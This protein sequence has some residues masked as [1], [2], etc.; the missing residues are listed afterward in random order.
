MSEHINVTFD[1]GIATLLL[2]LPG[3]NKIG[4][5]FGAALTSGLDQALAHEGLKGIVLGSGH[6]DFCVGADID[7]L[8]AERDPAKIVDACTQLNAL[9]RRIETC[10]VPVVAAL[11]GSALG[12]GYELALACH[13][14]IALDSGRI[15][16]G[17]P[18][19]SLGVIPGAGGT[20]R[21]PYIMGLQGAMEHMAAGTPLRAPKAL[22]KGMLN[23][24]ASDADDL[25]Q[26]ARAW[27]LENQGYKQ[28]WDQKR[29]KW[30]GGARPMTPA[31]MQL[32]IGASAFLYQK[33]AGAFAAPEAVIRAVAEGTKLK[34]DRGVEVETR[35]FAKLATSDQSKDMIRS[36]WYHR[37]AAEKR[38][39]GLEHGFKKVGI[40]GAGMMGAGLG[41]LSARTGCEVVIKDIGQ[42]QLDLAKEHVD[43]QIARMRHLSADEKQAIGERI[44]YT[45]DNGPLA[46]SD[47]II[48]AVIE[49][50]EIKHQVIK[51]VEPLL[52]PNG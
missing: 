10:G 34:F 13:Y 35:M 18:E 2:T 5:H 50:L 44:S 28:P 24:L 41:F 19:V 49:N 37:L 14:R 36:L 15:Q 23:A 52:A 48:E 51:E 21:L 26:K 20:Q 39:S 33:T 11:T 29:Y 3:V 16:V 9:Y 43:A 42:P 27:I 46:G 38:G 4:E 31:A 32:F 22:G 6:K 45:L 30:P 1:E 25:K 12:G 40:L 47:L 7:M 8:F 17:L